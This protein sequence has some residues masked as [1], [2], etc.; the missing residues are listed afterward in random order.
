ME[1]VIILTIRTFKKK[2]KQSVCLL[3]VCVCRLRVCVCL[4]QFPDNRSRTDL[5]SLLCLSV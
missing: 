2:I 3:S 4:C 1:K 5:C